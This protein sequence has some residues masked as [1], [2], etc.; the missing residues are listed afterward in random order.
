MNYSNEDVHIFE[1]SD[2]HGTGNNKASD[3]SE[4]WGIKTDG[5]VK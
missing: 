3:M 4:T 2:S 1:E 5:A